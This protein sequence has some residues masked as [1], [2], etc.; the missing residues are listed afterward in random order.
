MK[1]SQYILLI[2]LLMFE[3]PSIA[4]YDWE[5]IIISDS[6]EINM[7]SFDPSGN[8]YIA[9]NEG[10]YF[11]EDNYNWEQT[12]LTQYLSNIYINSNSTLYAGHN[13]LFRSFD[14]GVTWDSVFTYN[15]GF[16]SYC[17]IGDSVV[18]LGTW[19]G[20]FRSADS[21]QTWLQVI[22]AYNS[23]VFND[24]VIDEDG[25]LFSGSTSYSNLSPG[26][27][28]RSDDHGANWDLIGLEYHFI[29]SLKV[30]SESIL[31]AS[32]LG[33]YY[34]GKC[35]V[36]KSMDHGISWD[37]L[38]DGYQFM[39]LDISSSDVIA[40]GCYRWEETEVIF[41]SFDDGINWIDLTNNLPPHSISHVKF[42]PDNY[43]YSILTNEQHLFKTT[44]IV[45][46][47]E[48]SNPIEGDIFIYPNPAQ[49]FIHVRFGIV[50]NSKVMIT[51]MMGDVENG[52]SI[53]YDDQGAVI[54]ID[55]LETGI[56]FINLMNDNRI[57]KTNKFIKY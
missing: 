10:L 17:S 54:Y 12:S 23:E 36:Y 18:L 5:E 11:S 52:M 28:Y 3:L 31:F 6:T 16:S 32:T 57:K 48:N 47:V 14:D 33:Q 7:I 21:C 1:Y 56:Y 27:V 44:T 20:I 34:T 13:T 51:N 19:G 38:F 37:L 24:I 49:A 15:V 25:I 22:D 2:T 46:V 42:N 9:T 8:Q 35:G 41:G 53:K 4:Q 26:G 30:N 45:G 55:N 43:L 40:A 29:S 39:T 50:K